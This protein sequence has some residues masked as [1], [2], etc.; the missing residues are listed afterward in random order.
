MTPRHIDLGRR[1]E[2]AAAA[3]LAGLGW[4]IL[5]RN[6]RCPEGELD[7]VAHDGRQHVA[8]EVKTRASTALGEPVEAI[9]PP[10]AARLRRLANRWAAEHRVP[11]ALV[12]VDVLGLVSDGDG[13]LL[14]HLRG[15]C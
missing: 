7:I 3:H 8:C 9:T 2:S 14:D 10:K 11:A 15:V 1:G 13:F 5:D 6:W 12:R 4:M